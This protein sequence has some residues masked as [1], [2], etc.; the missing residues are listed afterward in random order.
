MSYGYYLRSDLAFMD[1]A[2]D[3]QLLEALR[4]G[5]DHGVG[6]RYLLLQLEGSAIERFPTFNADPALVSY[7]GKFPRTDVPALEGRTVEMPGWG[8]EARV[9]AAWLVT[10]RE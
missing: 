9:T 4:T 1:Q 7:L 8:L 10:L 5:Q 3:P 6:M 2:V